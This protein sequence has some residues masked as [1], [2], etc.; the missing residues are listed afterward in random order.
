MCLH[1]IL[2]KF[3]NSYL[4]SVDMFDIMYKTMYCLRVA[5]KNIGLKISFRNV[6]QIVSGRFI[7]HFSVMSCHEDIFFDRLKEKDHYRLKERDHD[8]LKRKAH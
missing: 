7:C 8:V 3:L 4:H 2:I 1:K 5:P 6:N